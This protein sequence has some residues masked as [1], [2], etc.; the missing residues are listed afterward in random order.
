M[1]ELGYNYLKSCLNGERN[2]IMKNTDINIRDPFVLLYEGKYYMYGTRGETCWG[3]ADGFDCYV[4][5]DLENWSDAIEVFHTPEGFWADRNYWAPEVYFYEGAFYMFASFK[6]EGMSRGTQ[7]LKADSP[8][9]PFRVH[10][11]RPITPDGWECLDGTLYVS[12]EG[13]PYMVFSHEWVDVSD[14]EIWSVELDKELTKPVAEPE[15]LFHASEAPWIKQTSRGAYVTDGPFMFRTKTGKLLMLW[16]SFGSEGYTEAIAVSDNDEIDGNWIQ[17]EELLFKKD[18][19]HGML[20][21][22]KDGQLML[23]LHSPNKR[24]LERPKFYEISEKG[25]EL[26]REEN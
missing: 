18:G 2:A 16:S 13:V 4:S 1:K 12:K 5:E 11:E 19:G 15:L 14:G 24:L 9:G 3:E 23:A 10:S 7:I 6:K 20:F 8:L 22:T 26:F 17:Q 25:D 21:R